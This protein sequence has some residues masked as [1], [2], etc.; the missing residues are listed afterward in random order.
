MSV[1]KETLEMV[2]LEIWKIMNTASKKRLPCVMLA[3]F[4][5]DIW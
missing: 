4:S 2:A 3:H 1:L 5:D